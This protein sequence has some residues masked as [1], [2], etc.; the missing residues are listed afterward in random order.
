MLFFL[1]RLFFSDSGKEENKNSRRPANF[2]N[3]R[4]VY[5][6]HYEALPALSHKKKI[7]ISQRKK[8]HNGPYRTG[9]DFWWLLD[10]QKENIY[11]ITEREA[12]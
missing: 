9:T 8:Q 12:K 5:G 4:D 7:E 10:K 3:D 1:G 6:I 2:N 11:N